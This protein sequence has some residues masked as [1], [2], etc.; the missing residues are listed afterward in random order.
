MSIRIPDE[1]LFSDE[2]DKKKLILLYHTTYDILDSYRDNNIILFNKNYEL[3]GKIHRL[4]SGNRFTRILTYIDRYYRIWVALIIIILVLTG[5]LTPQ[6][7]ELLRDAGG[8]DIVYKTIPPEPEEPK[9]E[10]KT[11]DN[12][13]QRS[14]PQRPLDNNKL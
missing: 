8:V 1:I 3:K 9:Q 5:K 11:W 14:K 4:E 10:P 6:L 7:A 13:A 12:T 2:Y